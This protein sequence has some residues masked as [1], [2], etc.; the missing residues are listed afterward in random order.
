MAN[1]DLVVGDVISPWLECKQALTCTQI[2][3]ALEQGSTYYTI[4]TQ[5]DLSRC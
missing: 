1:N 5:A 4:T 2:Q 3:A